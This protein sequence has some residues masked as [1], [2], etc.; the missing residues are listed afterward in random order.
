[1]AK[2]TTIKIEANDDGLGYAAIIQ[3]NEPLSRETKLARLDDLSLTVHR[4]L[5]DAGIRNVPFPT[6]FAQQTCTI[7][8]IDVDAPPPPNGDGLFTALKGDVRLEL[9]LRRLRLSL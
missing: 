2:A 1:L 4:V 6:V 5:R 7:I 8:Q 3:I 9:L